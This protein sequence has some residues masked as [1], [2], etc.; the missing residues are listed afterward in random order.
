MKE[1]KEEL[2]T[3]GCDCVCEGDTCDKCED[4]ECTESDPN[5]PLTEEEEK[6]LL[7]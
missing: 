3:T 5:V 7:I 2:E 1:E 6:K 4:C